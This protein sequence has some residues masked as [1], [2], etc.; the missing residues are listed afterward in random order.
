MIN[1]ITTTTT[2]I[3]ITTITALSWKVIF[4]SIVCFLWFVER[5]CS[6]YLFELNSLILLQLGASRK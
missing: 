5:V 3:T 1:I 2:T 4:L 6:F